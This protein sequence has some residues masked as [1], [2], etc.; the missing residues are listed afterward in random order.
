MEERKTVPAAPAD[1]PGAGE[2][3]RFE[4]LT[5]EQALKGFEKFKD[6]KSYPAFVELVTQLFA[7]AHLRAFKKDANLPLLILHLLDDG[8]NPVVD[9]GSGIVFDPDHHGPIRA[10]LLVLYKDLPVTSAKEI[11]DKSD[12][13]SRGYTSGGFGY[14]W[15]N[16]RRQ[17]YMQLRPLPYGHDIVKPDKLDRETWQL[18]VRPG[19]NPGRRES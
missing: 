2:G 4:S 7:S 10:G 12:T 9:T 3:S 6:R 8:K 17:P 13:L 1:Q 18:V 15:S 11:M 5:T 16:S 19:N 14:H